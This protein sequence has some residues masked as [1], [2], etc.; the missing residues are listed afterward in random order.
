MLKRRETTLHIL[1]AIDLESA[2][3]D[4]EPSRAGTVAAVSCVA[5]V[6]EGY[7]TLQGFERACSAEKVRAWRWRSIVGLCLWI[8]I[9]IYILS[10]RP[11][12]AYRGSTFMH[13]S[14]HRAN[15]PPSWLITGPLGPSM[16]GVMPPGEEPSPAKTCT[17]T[18][19]G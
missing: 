10:F 8:C 2:Q 19:A 16:S 11:P 5:A 12:F 15:P 17:R 13:T 18:R 7:D 4:P 6:Q 1:Y 14:A 9:Y 3:L